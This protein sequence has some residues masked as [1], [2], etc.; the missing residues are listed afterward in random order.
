MEAEI[1]GDYLIVTVTGYIPD[2]PDHEFAL[3]PPRHVLDQVRRMKGLVVSIVTKVC[4]SFLS[5][6][7]LPAA[8]RDEEAVI[9]WIPLVEAS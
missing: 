7:E 1:D 2:A 6:E 3:K 9:G 8:I 4:P 5:P